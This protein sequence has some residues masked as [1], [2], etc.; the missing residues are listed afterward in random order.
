MIEIYTDGSCLKNPDGPGGWA[1]CY[2]PKNKEEKVIIVSDGEKSTTNNR[3]ELTAIIEALRFIGEDK[4]D[5]EDKNE[6][7]IYTDSQL[8]INCATGVWKRNKNLDLWKLY[9]K[10]S[11]NKKLHFQWVKGHSGNTY[12]ELVDHHAYQEA[13]KVI[14]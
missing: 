12:N 1:F 9:D 5:K 8:C 11:K 7:K 14:K 4:K 13:N 2:I 3:M 10:Y 6:Y